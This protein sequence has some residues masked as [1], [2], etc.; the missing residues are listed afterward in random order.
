MD[1]EFVNFLITR[2]INIAKYEEGSLSDQSLLV[3]AFESR[4]I[5]GKLIYYNSL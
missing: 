1:Q 2:G 3:Q 4:K 5:Q